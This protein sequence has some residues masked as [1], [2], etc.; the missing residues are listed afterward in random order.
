[1]AF[2]LLGTFYVFVCLLFRLS[3]T[4]QIS[5][6]RSVTGHDATLRTHRILRV[7]SVVA[8]LFALG[9]LWTMALVAMPK[10]NVGLELAFAILCLVHGMWRPVDGLH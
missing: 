6:L 1:V 5:T 9:G 8:N 4:L 7:W 2:G 3:T 10:N